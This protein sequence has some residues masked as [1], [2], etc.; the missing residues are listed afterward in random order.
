MFP[1]QNWL[2]AQ[3]GGIPTGLYGKGE[4]VGKCELAHSLVRATLA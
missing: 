3:E 1:N 4:E 2:P